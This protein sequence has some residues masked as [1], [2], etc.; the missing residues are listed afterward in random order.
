[1]TT[2]DVCICT[3]RRASIAHAITSIDAQD[4]PPGVSISIIVA[5][6]DE[7]PSA[8][9]LIDTLASDIDTP[10]T[11]VHA[12]ARNISIARNACLDTAKGD[13]V[14]FLD[15][16]EVAPPNWL[17]DLL[18]RAQQ[19][20][21]NVVFG[22]ARAQ[23]DAGTPA[24]IIAQDYH[25]NVPET[26]GGV[27][28]TG[29]T[30][31]A[32]IERAHPLIVNE[33]F[34]LDKGRTGGEDTEFFFRL[35]RKGAKL[36]I[37]DKATVYEPVDPKRLSFKWIM[38]R[39]YRSGIS[40]GRHSEAQY[41][42]LARAKLFSLAIAKIAYCALAA[43]VTLPMPSQRN[44]WILRAGFHAGVASSTFNAREQELYG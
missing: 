2:I 9:D 24:W 25:S 20:P 39:K 28:Q 19:G 33:R 6:N 42:L 18:A 15:D 11:Y 34:R 4:T 26:R 10:I 36:G 22:T 7:T 38:T 16:D 3:F 29:H 12:P 32:M 44:F 31:N 21:F 40:Y 23:Y 30:C 13:W 1:M 8:K 37:S 27:V 5:D 41:T 14:A 43:L 35:W 17:S